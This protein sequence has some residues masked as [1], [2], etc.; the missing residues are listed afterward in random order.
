[1]PTMTSFQFGKHRKSVSQGKPV[2]IAILGQASVGKTALAVRFITKRFIGEYDPTLEST[3]QFRTF[4]D[5]DPVDFEILDTAGQEENA[6][7]TQAQIKWA[8]AFII[9]Y[10]V[11]DKCSYDEILRIKFLITRNKG[12]D[13]PV[14]IVGNK[15]DLVY[16]RMIPQGEGEK[17]AKTLSCQFSEISVRESYDDVRTAFLKLYDECK[18]VKGTRNSPKLFL[19]TKSSSHLKS[20]EKERRETPRPRERSMSVISMTNTPVVVTVDS[21]DSLD[22]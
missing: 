2:K 5:S 7:I 18:L 6:T 8:D 1:M 19:R 12:N 21:L 22:E 20:P 16:D 4:V 15:A 10:S 9:V 3:Y 11:T 14:M 13:T 17:L